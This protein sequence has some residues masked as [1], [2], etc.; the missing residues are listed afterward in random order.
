[1]GRGANS[2][3]IG[4]RHSGGEI[5]QVHGGHI[6]R[7]IGR[8][9]R[10]SKVCTSKGPKDRRVRL[11]A[12]TAIQFYDVQDR[13]GYD[14]PSKAVDWLIKKAKAA[15]DQLGELPTWLP[16]VSGNSSFNQEKLTEEED[17]TQTQPQPQEEFV[18]QDGG[19]RA[20][21]SILGGESSYQQL[22]MGGNNSGILPPS[23]H[24]ADPIQLFFP[25]GV[26]S[27]PNSSTMQ[28][29]NFSQQGILSRTCSQSQ[30]LRLSLQSFQHPIHHHQQHH[31]PSLQDHHHPEQ[32][33]YSGT[34][35][36]V[37]DP[38]SSSGWPDEHTTETGGF[39]FSTP[40]MLQPLFS[41]NQIF[42]Q[43]GPLQSSNT[44]TVRGWIDPSPSS[45]DHQSHHIH[46]SPFAGM[47]F[48]SAG[49]ISGFDFPSRIQG[50]EEEEHDHRISDKPSSASSDSQHNNNIMD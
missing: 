4:L 49:G 15:I 39:I 12:H 45:S 34:T 8:K 33:L 13:L 14:R 17:Q 30:D 11:S 43:G 32:T 50:E 25:V 18:G 20:T 35:Q 44:Q 36:L 42:S 2:S 28:F 6:I 22:K 5:I 16:T 24:A 7:S 47:G 38:S 10:H 41:Q 21:A 46:Q 1:M 40:R 3:R 29:Q 9:D 19:R 37:F 48:A 26:S 31:D 27:E 23:M